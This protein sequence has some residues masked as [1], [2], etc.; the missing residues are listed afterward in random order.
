ML[1]DKPLPSERP[2]GIGVA[3]F[4]MA[5][6]LSKRGSTIYFVCRGKAEETAD[7][8]SHLRVHTIR[9]YSRD[10]LAASL[11]LLREEGCELVHVHSSSAIPSL[12]VARM[13][14]RSTILHAHGDEPLH[15]IRLTVIRNIGMHLSERVIATSR[16]TRGDIIKNHHVS[17]GKVIVAYNG[18]DIEE[19]RPSSELSNVSLKYALEGY[20]KMIL[21][22]GTLQP[23][24]GQSKMVECLPKIL[25]RWPR[26]VYVNVGAPYELGF[27]TR[28]LERAE[29]LGVSRAIR[30]L[31]GL[32]QYD[33]VALINAADLCVHPST[34]EGFGLAVVEEMACGKAVVAFNADSLPEIVDNG[35]DGLLVDPNN[36]EELTGALSDVIGDSEFAKRLGDAARRKVE[37]RFTWDRTASRLEQIYSHILA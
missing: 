8:N 17:P 22:V 28:L 33:L 36:K 16:N 14:R 15:P 31:S 37:G 4:N 13:L 23:S 3:A 2:T 24:K 19:F 32:P 25:Q 9:R 7:L 27:Q 10:N 20:D 21:S 18:V 35:V 5:L 1:T 29:E 26:L 12:I 11:A 6:A 34:R 30:L